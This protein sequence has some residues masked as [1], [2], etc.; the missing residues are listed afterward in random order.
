MLAVIMLAGAAAPWAA[1]A[2]DADSSAPGPAE[3]F[4]QLD[5]DGDGLLG[6][7]EIPEDKKSLFSR[8]LR[9]GDANDDDKLTVDEFA[10]GL[11]GGS[12]GAE[13]DK[14]ERPA[15][16]Q[17][18]RGDRDGSN[19]GR[20]GE[21]FKR[22]DRD[23]DG[24]VTLEEVPQPGR[25]RFQKLLER[26]DQD[27]DGALT[28]REFARG[29]AQ[30]GRPGA[31]AKR[32]PGQ[33]GSDRRPDSA[34]F[35]D[36]ADRNGDGKLTADE[37]PEE[38]RERIERLIERADKDGDSALSKGEFAAAMSVVRARQAG[39]P[40]RKRPD[41][42]PGDAKKPGQKR[43][44]KGAKKTARA[45]GP[46]RQPMGERMGLFAALDA[47]GDGSLSSEEISA[48]PEVLKKLD[49]DDDGTL[50]PREALGRARA[51]NKN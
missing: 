13:E 28:L 14:P 17:R 40:P 20:G 36:R 44:Q 22:L 8:L 23:G 47:D 1:R 31:P 48:A 25:E 16:G 15:R 11:S 5:V 10:Q 50:S 18:G 51:K 33:P 7:D 38:R 29:A 45:G 43:D 34:Q 46:K 42:S 6:D 9:R 19:R 26:A 2:D 41:A 39:Q 35:F 24:K 32:T 3:L 21:F 27:D 30:A 12:A 4:E 37:V 49:R